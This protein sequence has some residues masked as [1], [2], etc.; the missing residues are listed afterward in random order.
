MNA[1]ASADLRETGGMFP[2]K[3]N[4]TSG[5]PFDCELTDGYPEGIILI[6]SFRPSFSRGASG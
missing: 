6:L 1:F 4:I 3:W 5:Q 2:V